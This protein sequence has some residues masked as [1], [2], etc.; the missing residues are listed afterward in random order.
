MNTAPAILL[1]GLYSWETD[2]RLIHAA[3]SEKK[4]KTGS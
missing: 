2:Q 1:P 4:E 3:R